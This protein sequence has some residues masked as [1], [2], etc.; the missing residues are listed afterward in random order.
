MSTRTRFM[1]PLA[2]ST[3]PQSTSSV[4]APIMARQFCRLQATGAG[5]MPPGEI[6]PSVTTQGIST[7][8]RPMAWQQAL[9]QH[10]HREWVASL[11]EGMQNGFRIGLIPT[12]ACRSSTR[13]HPSADKHPVVVSEYLREQVAAGYMLGPFSP[14]QCSGMIISSIG[15]VPKLPRGSLGS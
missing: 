9:A 13:N 14:G 15:V 7:P 6:P 12:T 2:A 3:L 1:Y 10:P 4:M 8:L 5:N 11:L